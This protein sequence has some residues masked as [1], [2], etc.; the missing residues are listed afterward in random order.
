MEA[1]RGAGNLVRVSV[2]EVRAAGA[3]VRIVGTGQVA[4]LPASELSVS[5]DPVLPLWQ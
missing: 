3:I 1:A 2:L 4:W 5:Y